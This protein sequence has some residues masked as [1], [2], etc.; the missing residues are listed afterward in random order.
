M[1][2][3]IL[4]RPIVELPGIYPD[5]QFISFS[6]EE[7][8]IYRVLEDSFR[9]NLNQHF[10]SGTAQRNYSM[11]MVQL[12]RLRQCTS[13]PFLLENTIKEALGPTDL[14]RLKSQLKKLSRHSQPIYE[15]IS[16]WVQETEEERAAARERGE[17]AG[18]PGEKTPFG[19]SEFGK[20]FRMGK[21]LESL[22]VEDV[23]G[24]MVC[25]LCGDF[26]TDPWFID[27]HHCYCGECL[28]NYMASEVERHPDLQFY[29]CPE[30]SC[31]KFF[32]E[33][34]PFEEALEENEEE[35]R[36]QSGGRP[37]QKKSKT[38]RGRATPE[39]D[40][41][42]GPSGWLSMCMNDPNGYLLPSAK[43][44]ALKSQILK[45]F[46]QAPSD[47]I[48]IFTQFRLVVKI[49]ALVCDGEEWGNVSFTG[50]MGQDQRY[51]AINRFHKDP[52]VRIMIA[53]LKCGGQALNLTC[54][55]RVISIDLWWNRLYPSFSLTTARTNEIPQ[56]L[57]NSRPL[58]ESFESD[59]RRRPTSAALS[60]RIASTRDFSACRLTKSWLLIGPCRIQ[61]VVWNPYPLR[62]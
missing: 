11:F 5:T 4:G 13:H 32:V 51:E 22:A 24:R 40:L 1:K 50:D 18:E 23:A 52:D 53:G 17:P 19:K 6:R 42:S 15:Q 54:A 33:G 9:E 37:R 41:F 56:I 43:M 34:Q 36:S 12:L 8:V 47:K 35:T 57:S 26:P 7:K 3:K 28:R 20:F 59:K 60:S 38:R 29:E 44:I 39:G 58:A 55:N 10:A 27:C 21:F 25:R 31:R 61:V 46:D 16:Q 48:L 45:W 49:I 62:T 30:P 2:D 14:M